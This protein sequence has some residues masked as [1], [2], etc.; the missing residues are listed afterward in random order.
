MKCL[1][2]HRS[3]TMRRIFS[4]V[5]R[6]SGCAEI[7]EAEEW[8][9]AAGQLLDHAIDLVITEWSI[10]GMDGIE[11][12]KEI[13]A[14]EGTSKIP[15]LIVS[16]RNSREDVMLAVE[17]GVSGYLLKPF[18]AETLRLKLQQLLEGKR[19]DTAEV[20]D[21]PQSDSTQEALSGAA[22]ATEG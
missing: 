4:K 12:V 16:P 17:A 15:I 20:G 22:T 2:I 1:V 11:L 14:R 21:P 18:T 5:L 19:D 7:T 10:A 13:R 3:A 9:E 8:D 6:E